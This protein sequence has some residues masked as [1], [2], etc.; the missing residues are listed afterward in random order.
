MEGKETELDKTIIEAIK[1]PLTHVVR[2]S[3]DHGIESSGSARA[4]GKPPKAAYLCAP[5]TKADRSISRS[6]TT[7]PESIWSS[8]SNKAV[9]TRT[10]HRRAGRAH[11]R[12]RNLQPDLSARPFHRGKVTNVSGRGVGMDVVKTNIEKI[13]GTV[14]VQSKRGSGHH[15]GSRFR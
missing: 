3:V 7:A 15:V 10:D 2:N 9:R 6:P 4:S 5:F 12:A 8:V 1:D 13:G 11:E 14:D